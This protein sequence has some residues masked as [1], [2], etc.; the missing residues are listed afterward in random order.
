MAEFDY[1]ASGESEAQARQA[2]SYLFA[3][4]SIGL[5]ATGVLSGLAVAQTS[6]ASDSVEI[7]AGAAVVQAS[8]LVGAS[9][10]VNNTTK[11]LDVLTA[12]PMGG[13]PRNDVVAF[14]TL[15][16]LIIVIVGTPN[17]SP[18]DPT[19][20]TT[21]CPLARL[22]HGAS[23]T[24]IP[25]ANIDDL[26]SYTSLAIGGAWSAYVPTWTN[27][28]VGNGTLVAR[29][30]EIGKTVHVAISFTFG[31]TSA[32]G[33]GVY[34]S[35]PINPASTYL[36]TNVLLGS[37]GLFDASGAWRAGGAFRSG[38]NVRLIVADGTNLSATAPWTWATGDIISINLTYE[39][40]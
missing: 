15:T 7:A 24:T 27:L 22:R 33:T 10:L 12:N 40:A 3:Q 25:T 34:V 16:D 32:A 17:A 18:T 2:T 28:T 39:A 1:L 8:V 5:A 14:D 19:V 13:L 36:A 29:Y 37:V 23:A 6:T 30:E 35:L 31:S 11:T 9:L 20:P 26:R 21:A 38:S 4:S